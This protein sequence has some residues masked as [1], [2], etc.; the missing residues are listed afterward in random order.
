MFSK[1]EGKFDDVQYVILKDVKY[2]IDK[3]T[4]KIVAEETKGRT[5]KFKQYKYK[6][7]GQKGLKGASKH[8]SVITYGIMDEEYFRKELDIENKYQKV[9]KKIHYK[10]LRK[11][12]TQSRASI[13]LENLKLG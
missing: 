7:I 4:G 5:Y 9:N 13:L 1:L 8:T 3:E 10:R 12:E 6:H 11:T 2:N